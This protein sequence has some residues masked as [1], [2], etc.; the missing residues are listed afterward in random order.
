EIGRGGMGAVFL[1]ERADDEYQKRVAIKL[2]KRGMDTDSVLRH[3]RNE[4]QILASFDHPNIARLFDGGTTENGLPY[5]VME[6]VE[7]LA[8]DRYCNTHGL[9][10]SE[11]LKLFLEV[12]AAV[13]YA[14]RHTVIHRDIKP[15]NI[16][17]TSEGIPKLLDF[18][19]A[20]LLHTD[21]DAATIVTATGLRVMT[22]EY[23]S[24]EQLEGRPV[25]AATDV[26][27]LGMVLYQVL[28]G[29]SP[30]DFKSRSPVEIARA[31][32]ET[33]PKKP[34]TAIA[35]S[36]GS[37]K[38]QIPNP[39]LLRGDLDN[40]VLMA[41]R[42]DPARRYQSAEQL[43]EDIRRYLEGLPV[44]ARKDTIGYRSAK[45]LRRNPILAAAATMCLLL[46]LAVGWLLREQLLA[47]R[48]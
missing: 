46:T 38:S 2:I 13:S 48:I 15:S 8:I 40:V 10:I 36:D 27:S 28:T 33:E 39:K 9:S 45:F 3:F 44:V 43:S 34:S 16:L 4:R 6:C 11:R 18:G 47:P 17:V 5:F 19:I 25:T 12:C 42:K 7:G 31:I 14:H 22:P 30:Y 29:R 24:P 23:G 37:F 32:T 41:L 20:K 35:I 1:A 26:Y 21:G